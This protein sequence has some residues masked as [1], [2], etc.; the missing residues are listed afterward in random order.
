MRKIL[1]ILYFFIIVQFIF[2]DSKT[3][4]EIVAELFQAVESWFGTP[5]VLGGQDKSGIDC[6]GFVRELYEK[7]FNYELPRTVTLQK[8]LGKTVTGKF[9]PGDLLFF[10]TI[11]GVSH[12]GI[13][14]FDNKFIHAASAGPKVGIIKSSLDEKYYKERYL[15]AKRIV[16]LPSYK[17][18][19]V[20]QAANYITFYKFLQ[21]GKIVDKSVLFKEN[22]LIFFKIKN[23]N[24]EKNLKLLFENKKTKNIESID[25]N[26]TD[27]SQIQNIKLK[28]GNYSVKLVK[29]KNL[30]YQK[31][32]IEN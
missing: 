28:S 15:F 32:I 21:N 18:E 14:V 31:D 9:E 1:F 7:I 30:I 23:K 8:D 29:D 13:F 27:E 25:L 16:N 6:S 22:S 4:Q 11:G 26:Y 24:N 3:R 10:D 20:E 12:V 17:K 2:G 5:Y 19:K